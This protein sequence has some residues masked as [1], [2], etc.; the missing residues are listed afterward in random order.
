MREL[1]PEQVEQRRLL[2]VLKRIREYVRRRP[3]LEKGWNHQE[4]RIL[5][6]LYLNR[7]RLEYEKR[8]RAALAKNPDFRRAKLKA[9]W[10]LIQGGEKD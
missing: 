9:S 2:R 5:V 7:Y 1:T 8:L 3:L 6:K 4:I 10:D